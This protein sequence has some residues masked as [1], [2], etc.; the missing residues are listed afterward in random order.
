MAKANT[1]VGFWFAVKRDL[2]V[3]A[4]VDYIAIFYDVLFTFQAPFP[5]SLA[6]DSPLNWM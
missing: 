4:E 5:A 6:P 3:E 2:N 1:L